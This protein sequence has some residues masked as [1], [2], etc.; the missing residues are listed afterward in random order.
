MRSYLTPTLMAAGLAFATFEPASAQ[1][2][3]GPGFTYQG[4]LKAGGQPANGTYDFIFE[5]LNSAADGN[6]I[7]QQD[8]VSGVQ[9]VDGL[10]TVELNSAGEFGPGAFDGEA[11]WLQIRVKEENGFS[12]EALAPRQ[13]VCA[14]P[15]AGVA[16]RVP[17]ID[18]HSLNSP[19]GSIVDALV[20]NDQGYVGIGTAHPVNPLQI[21]TVSESYG[22]WHTDGM[23]A[24]ATWV[25]PYESSDGAWIGAATFSP[26]HFY[27]GDSDAQ[28]TLTLDGDVGI[29]TN[30]PAAKLEVRGDVRLGAN[31]ND[32]A[33]AGEENLRLVRGRVENNATV[34]MGAGFSV[35]RPGVGVYTITFSRPFAGTPSVTASAI[36]NVGG[37]ST[38]VMSANGSS[39]QVTVF[40]EFGNRSNI[41][42]FDLIAVG[43]R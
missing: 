7:G 10:F 6:L 36:G 32:F 9:V 23:H 14:A 1:T 37:F 11:R 18:G 35:M 24:V 43:P 19:D 38:M 26:L 25:G 22:L 20:V 17:G 40:D 8:P 4:Q 15:V 33:A 41:T 16:M 30:A 13:P 5:L 28:M 42:G 3:L 31:G 39:A 21:H 29:G 2:P 27:T 34:V 12:Y